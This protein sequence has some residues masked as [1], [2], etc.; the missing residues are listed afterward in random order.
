MTLGLLLSINKVKLFRSDLN[1]FLKVL[2]SVACGDASFAFH[3]VEEG[4]EM[5]VTSVALLMFG[6][7]FVK[8]FQFLRCARQ[9]VSVLATRPSCGDGYGMTYFLLG[10]HV[11]PLV[12]AD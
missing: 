11:W 2:C 1:S 4:G 6:S 9:V 5:V 10:L 7:L 8:E 12:G 3:L